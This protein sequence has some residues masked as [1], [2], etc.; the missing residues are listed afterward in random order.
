MKEEDSAIFFD[1]INVFCA[2]GIVFNPLHNYSICSPGGTM[3][4]INFKIKVKT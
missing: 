2:S 1:E 3:K 4:E